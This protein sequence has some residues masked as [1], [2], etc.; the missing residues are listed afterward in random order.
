MLKLIL[1]AK[2]F[3]LTSLFFLSITPLSHAWYQPG[4]TQLD[5]DQIYQEKTN[6]CWA[7]S[8]EMVLEYY[9]H[10]ETQQNIANYGTP[11]QSNTWNW[12]YGSSSNPTRR[13]VD[14]ILDHLGNI[15]TIRKKCRLSLDEIWQQI[16]AENDPFVMRW[17]WTSGG[18]HSLVGCGWVFLPPNIPW[19]ELNDPWYGNSVSS[20]SWVIGGQP[21]DDREWTHSLIIE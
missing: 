3:L 4:V 6:W 9:G 21:G 12:L 19:I 17:A 2:Y 1:K 7:A 11:T 20:Y 14:R 18:G 5:V 16:V 15:D 8:A 10:N 13:G